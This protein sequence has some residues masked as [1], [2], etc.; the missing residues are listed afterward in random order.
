MQESI[1]DVH[2]IIPNLYSKDDLVSI[3]SPFSLTINVAS[4]YHNSFSKLMECD[5]ISKKKNA[6]V[7]YLFNK[8]LRE[9]PFLKHNCS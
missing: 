7:K 1:E 2:I 3:V 9:P 6:Y 5:P 8:A 4:N